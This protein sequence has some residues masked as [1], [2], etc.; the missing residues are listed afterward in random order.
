[1]AE[2]Q[3]IIDCPP[4][5]G[6]LKR[7]VAFGVRTAPYDVGQERELGGPALAEPNTTPIVRYL[8]FNRGR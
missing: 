3:L 2:V 8:C 5:S 4:T 6:K 1:M 7:K